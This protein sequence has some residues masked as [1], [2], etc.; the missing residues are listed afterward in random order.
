MSCL[1]SLYT[2][3]QAGL[4]VLTRSR[5]SWKCPPRGLRGGDSGRNA[6]TAL[7]CR[8]PTQDEEKCQKQL[9]EKLP[10]LLI[11]WRNLC[12]W[13]KNLENQNRLKATCESRSTGGAE[14]GPHCAQTGGRASEPT[15]MSVRQA[16]ADLSPCSQHTGCSWRGGHILMA[17]AGRSPVEVVLLPWSS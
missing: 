7:L 14:L 3:G 5:A 9:C 4:R 12:F 16:T 2:S 17:Q 1:Y 11:I 15:R 8:P 13:S 10:H 6:P